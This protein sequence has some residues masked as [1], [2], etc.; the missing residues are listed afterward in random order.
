MV[1]VHS[2]NLEEILD[3]TAS[4]GDNLRFTGVQILDA[5]GNLLIPCC[6]G[7][8]VDSGVEALDERASQSARSSSES[9]RAF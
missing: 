3:R 5:A 8:F 1:C 6:L 7:S 9:E 2:V 4:R